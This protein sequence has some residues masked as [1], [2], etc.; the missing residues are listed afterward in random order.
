MEG[1]GIDEIAG[2]LRLPAG[3]VKTRMRKARALLKHTLCGE[4]KPC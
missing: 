1:Y 4:V 3:T 2:M